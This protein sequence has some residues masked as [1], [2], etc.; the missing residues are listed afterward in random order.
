MVTS[1]GQTSLASWTLLCLDLATW[2]NIDS[3]MF[4][5]D[6]E[7]NKSDHVVVV[8]IEPHP[9]YVSIHWGYYVKAPFNARSIPI[10]NILSCHF[11]CAVHNWRSLCIWY[12]IQAW[13]V[14]QA[15]VK[16][17]ANGLSDRSEDWYVYHKI[18]IKRNRNM[19]CSQSIHPSFLSFH[20]QDPKHRP[21]T[22]GGC[23]CG[24]GGD[25]R[26]RRRPG[27]HNNEARG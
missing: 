6:I 26:A 24:I 15:S 11:L 19:Q 5:K 20:I 9:V 21:A 4:M 3:E 12:D 18:S 23:N 14:A 1:A 10:W 2:F 25:P 27:L 17:P 8:Y 16:K 7:I 22:G 13:P